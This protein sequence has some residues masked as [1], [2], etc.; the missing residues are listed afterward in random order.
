MRPSLLD[1]ALLS[2]A[3]AFVPAGMAHAQGQEE[4]PLERIDETEPGATL[5]GEDTLEPPGTAEEQEDVPTG[6][7]TPEAQVTP[8]GEPAVVEPSLEASEAPGADELEVEVEPEVEAEVG[9]PGRG[10]AGTGGAAAE[11]FGAA[12]SEEPGE[13]TEDDGAAATEED[14]V[15]FGGTEPQVAPEQQQAQQAQRALQQLQAQQ[16]AMLEQ[17][18]AIQQQQQELAERTAQLQQLEEERAAALEDSQAARAARIEGYG[19]TADLLIQADTALV[20]GELD[21]DVMLEAAIEQLDGIAATAREQGRPVEAQL[22]EGA[23][24]EVL[25]AVAALEER[26][27]YPARLLLQNAG[28]LL[29]QARIDARE[30][31]PTAAQ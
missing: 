15:G 1:A 18:Q 3:F 29:G 17:Q 13:E 26:D 30:A 11:G 24:A 7:P 21:V 16:Q 20:S 31:Q 8:S 14:A 5:P 22:A 28:V 27:V 10:E 9:A 4:P 12:E 19:E 25:R 2:L 6:E 23:R